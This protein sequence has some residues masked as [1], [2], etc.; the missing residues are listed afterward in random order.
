MCDM[1]IFFQRN[2]SMTSS[3]P[4][5]YNLLFHHLRSMTFNFNF[6]PIERAERVSAVKQILDGSPN[7]SHLEVEWNDFR[8]CSQTYSNLKH[9]HLVLDRL[10]PEPKQ[11]FNVRR[12]TQLAPN[13]SCIETSGA[14]I[15]LS[16]NLVEFVLKVI[17]RFH[18]LVYLILNKDGLY[19]FKE[20]K[21]IMFKEKLIAAGHGRLFDYKNIRIRFPGH[22]ELCIWL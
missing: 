3:C 20:E 22:N 16:D 13:L 17:R 4:S 7:L 11:H 1:F 9:V 6:K 10:S 8:H 21:K 14:I 15:M 5:S 2:I 12:L 19:P 18:Q